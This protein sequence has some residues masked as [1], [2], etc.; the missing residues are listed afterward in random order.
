MR[1]TK[2]RSEAAIMLSE[3]L[4][5]EDM[6]QCFTDQ[7]IFLKLNEKL[8]YDHHIC[9]RTFQRYK[10]AALLYGEMEVEH[11]ADF[12]PIYRD[13]YNRILHSQAD[14]K[15][16]L[17][18]MMKN[19]EGSEWHRLK[20]IMERKFPDFNLR[21]VSQKHVDEMEMID[22]HLLQVDLQDAMKNLKEEKIIPA[23]AITPTEKPISQLMWER[24]A[25]EEAAAQIPD[26]EL[27]AFLVYWALEQKKWDD[28]HPLMPGYR[29]PNA[30]LQDE[31]VQ[32]Y[33]ATYHA[34]EKEKHKWMKGTLAA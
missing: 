18:K 10:A 4:L 7:Q 23:E 26:S 32:H 17:Y 29:F 16:T 9:Y 25:L 27:S 5:N 33:E 1:P 31:M 30:K 20:W 22:K 12:D 21:A 11:Q 34:W 8:G 6:A 2:Y 13:L 19:A 28:T 15:L 24:D 3:M 14:Q